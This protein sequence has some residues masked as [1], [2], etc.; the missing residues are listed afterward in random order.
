MKMYFTTSLKILTKGRLIKAFFFIFIN[1]V[2]TQGQQVCSAFLLLLCLSLSGPC[3]ADPHEEVLKLL[4]QNLTDQAFTLVNA[5]LKDHP[6]DPQMRFWQGNLWVK[7]GEKS[8]ASDVF[9][10]LTQDY[11][12]LSEPHNNL[13]ILQF[14]AGE[15]LKAKSS[16]EAALKLEP[17]YAL[18]MENLADTYLLLSRT[19]ME[20][21][22]STD[23]KS[24]SAHNKLEL[25]N[26]LLLDWGKSKK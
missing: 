12:E 22:V 17:N 25:I 26:Q 3:L 20:Q 11:P 23:P 5:Y 18:A 15:Y 13:G 8:L 21:V 6:Q 16:F 19:T 7:K 4:K 1:K 14:E 2:R 9:L 24:K 10:R